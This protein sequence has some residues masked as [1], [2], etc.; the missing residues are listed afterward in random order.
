MKQRAQASSTWS[1][2]HSIATPPHSLEKDYESTK[3]VS[4]SL[5]ARSALEKWGIQKMGGGGTS[6]GTSA[7]ATRAFA[8]IAL[9]HLTFVGISSF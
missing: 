7:S 1:F 9:R 4:K 5:D 3:V 8:A 6:G 2:G